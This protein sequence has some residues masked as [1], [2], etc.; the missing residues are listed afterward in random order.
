MKLF[1]VGG[2]IRDGLMGLKSKDVD[3]AVEM[4]GY[5]ED[6]GIH[7]DVL[8]HVAYDTMNDTLKSQG[9]KIFQKN[10]DCYTTRAQFPEDHEHS[11]VADFVMCRKEIRYIPGTRQPI[12]KMGTILDDLERR[13]FTVNAIA[14][15]LETGRLLDP[16]EGIRDIKDKVLRCP[17]STQ[18]S[19]DDDPLRIIRAFRLKVTKGFEM[20]PK[21]VGAIS[22]F[23][24]EKYNV[25]SVER[26]REELLKMFKHDTHETLQ[27]LYAM[28]LRNPKL[29]DKILPKEMWLEPTL[30]KRQLN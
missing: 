22:D 29:Y 15:D 21:M 26:T 2:H 1:E 20:S 9:Y 13:D 5:F 23:D 3:Y 11:G 28:K 4:I 14:K 7:P 17:V 24:P 18:A 25:V 10:P 8:P 6:Q 30:K 27:I 19:F 12:V 16:Y